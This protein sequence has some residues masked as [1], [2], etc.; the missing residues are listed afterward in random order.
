MIKARNKG[1]KIQVIV[2]HLIKQLPSPL[3]GYN[4]H[5]FLNNLFVF[6]RFVKYARFQRVKIINTCQDKGGINKELLKLKKMNKRD[7][8]P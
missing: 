4:Y 5:V 7:V 8:I 3:K 1:N 2:L 6:T